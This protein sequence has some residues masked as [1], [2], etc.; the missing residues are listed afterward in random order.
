MES[1]LS[2]KLKA[3][4][5][6]YHLELQISS[7]KIIDFLLIKLTPIISMFHVMI[8]MVYLSYFTNFT[9]VYIFSLLWD[10]MN[11]SYFTWRCNF[12][13]LVRVWSHNTHHKGC[14]YSKM[15]LKSQRVNWGKKTPIVRHQ[16]RKVSYYIKLIRYFEHHYTK[17]V[18]KKELTLNNE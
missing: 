17:R 1:R 13:W 5:S 11:F 8:K 3:N 10:E 18:P 12:L 6:E 14:N 15:H 16:K 9:E 2:H 7:K 4:Q